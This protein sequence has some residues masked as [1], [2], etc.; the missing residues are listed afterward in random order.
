MKRGDLDYDDKNVYWMGKVY[1]RSEM[2]EGDL[3]LPWEA[4]AYKRTKNA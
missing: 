3:D 1:P 2:N 4:E